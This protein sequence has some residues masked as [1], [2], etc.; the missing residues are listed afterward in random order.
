MKF[1]F[2]REA[3]NITRLSDANILIIDLTVH[4]RRFAIDCFY[5]IHSQLGASEVSDRLIT[6]LTRANKSC[7]TVRL[8]ITL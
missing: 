3:Y 8:C 4:C 6:L 7:E 1:Y 2:I 5:L